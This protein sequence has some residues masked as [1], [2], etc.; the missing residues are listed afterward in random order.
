MHNRRSSQA[1]TGWRLLFAAVGAV[2]F[3]LPLIDSPAIR[4]QERAPRA[5][6]PAFDVVSIRPT[7]LT[8]PGV[9]Q[10]QVSAGSL[11]IEGYDIPLLLL[12]AFRVK[13]YQ[14]VDVPAWAKTA[15]YD[16]HGKTT[17]PV[18]RRELWPML[19]PVL[20]DR[21]RLRA[22]REE[23]EMPVYTLTVERSGR[24]PEPKA[25]CYDPDGPM[26]QA[27]TT[28]HGQRPLL[29]CGTTLAL[30][31]PV[32][33]TIWGTKVRM[34]ALA[35][36][37]TNLLRRHVVDNTGSDDTFDLELTFALDGSIP[38]VLIPETSGKPNIFTA[39]RE[40][41]GLTLESGRAPVEVL[42]VD[43]IEPPSEN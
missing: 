9:R 21:F 31:G 20:E 43:R 28:P 17:Q 36:E 11:D 42:V 7:G 22:H 38:G 13:P 18:G 39:M 24:L 4:A 23:R 10:R 12:M 1:K 41:L 3:A 34:P 16:I 2:T 25:V 6:A 29:A 26:P 27:V 5:D 37:L 15:R 14:L 33:G 35:S 40:Q 30:P 32:H 8:G 19:V